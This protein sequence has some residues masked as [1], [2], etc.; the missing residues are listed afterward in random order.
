MF[1][2]RRGS[3]GASRL[4]H[5]EPRGA[6]VREFFAEVLLKRRERERERSFC[7]RSVVRFLF[8]R[9][10]FGEVKDIGEIKY[11]PGGEWSAFR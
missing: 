2:S 11:I 3:R 7:W 6:S 10:W 5:T 1:L 4:I 8:C 9:R